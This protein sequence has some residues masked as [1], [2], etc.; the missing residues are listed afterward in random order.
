M[1]AI[2]LLG[3]AIAIFAFGRWG[4]RNASA[5][6]ATVA[7]STESRLRKERA[8]RRGGIAWQ[9]GAIVPALAAVM[10]MLDV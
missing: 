10:V 4:Q 6:V 7:L 2:G 3:L 5:L 8:M 9:A 1:T